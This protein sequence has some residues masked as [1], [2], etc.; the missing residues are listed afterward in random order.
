MDTL[1][2]RQPS[3]LR[4]L[5]AAGWRPVM[6]G[7]REPASRDTSRSCSGSGRR[8]RSGLFCPST[9]GVIVMPV[10]AF[11]MEH[12][13]SPTGCLLVV[14]D[15]D[16]RLRAVDWQ[17]HEQ[18]LHQLL[19][20]QYG[21]DAVRLRAASRASGASRALCAY[22]EGD[23]G[24]L[25]GLPVATNGTVFQRMVW[26]ALRQIPAGQT[27][28]YGA[29][30]ARIGQPRAVRAVGLANG[31]NPVSI[32]VPCHRVIGAGGALTGFGGGLERK[33]WLLAHEGARPQAAMEFP[34][35]S[36]R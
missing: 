1:P 32:V 25:A 24:C 15:D 22:F 12:L 2:Y 11:S 35:P 34:P 16:G 3:T 14:T 30:A 9:P 5:A 20:R 18:R 10:Q 19:R 26:D 21:A 6:A 33:R 27:V 23:T 7:R 13:D 36:N 17:D 8:G 4:S 28:S 29:L 31:A